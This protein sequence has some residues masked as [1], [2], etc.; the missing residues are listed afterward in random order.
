MW[1]GDGKMLYY[2]ERKTLTAVEVNSR[3]G[4]FRTGTRT[5][6]F[7]VN[8]EDEE[9]RNRF[10]VTKDGERFLVIVK[11]EVKPTLGL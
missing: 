8:I 5:A 3:G 4:Q 10:L 6:L 9:H 11:E 2:L 1:R 7:N